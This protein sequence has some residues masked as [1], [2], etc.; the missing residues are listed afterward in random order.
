MAGLLEAEGVVEVAGDRLGGA[1]TG[2]LCANANQR[3]GWAG[4]DPSHQ[5]KLLVHCE[6]VDEDDRL[7]GQVHEEI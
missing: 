3:R 4:P 7:A 2:G 1:S 5:P 6:Q